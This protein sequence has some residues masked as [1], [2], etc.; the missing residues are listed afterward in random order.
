[1]R[2]IC[3]FA[4]LSACINKSTDKLPNGETKNLGE[5]RTNKNQT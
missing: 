1:V 3:K 2:E 4:T 5:T